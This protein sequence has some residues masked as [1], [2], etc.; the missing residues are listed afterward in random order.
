LR[1]QYDEVECRQ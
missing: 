1:N